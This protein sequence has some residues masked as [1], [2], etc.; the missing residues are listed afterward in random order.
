MTRIETLSGL[1]QGIHT[2]LDIGTDHGYVIIEALK[3]GY[4][5]S[6]I[7]CDVNASPLENAKQNIQNAGLDDKVTFV[8]SNGFQSVN[9]PYD[10]VLIAGMGMHLMKDILSQPHVKAKKYIL[11]AN[12]HIDQLRTYLMNHHFKIVDEITIY[13]KFHYVILICELGQMSLTDFDLYVGPILRHKPE[14]L[15]YYQNQARILNTNYERATGDKK[16]KIGIRLQYIKT[17]IEQLN[18]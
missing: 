9:K 13:D 11:Q 1:T 12:N 5:T 14:A 18:K 3:N 10:G 15:P 7:A 16:M 2:L 6:A 4:I 17:V 8:Q